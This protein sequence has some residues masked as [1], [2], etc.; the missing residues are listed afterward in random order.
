MSV[1]DFNQIKFDSN[2]IVINIGV[3]GKKRHR[4][5]SANSCYVSQQTVLLIFKML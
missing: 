4:L 5:L 2:N 1:D 3:H